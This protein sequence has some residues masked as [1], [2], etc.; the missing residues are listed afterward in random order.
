[1]YLVP[2]TISWGPKTQT[3][4]LQG[5]FH[6]QT[7]TEP[8]ESLN[9]FKKKVV[10]ILQKLRKNQRSRIKRKVD[11]LLREICHGTVGPEYNDY[12]RMIPGSH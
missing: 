11:M 12:S 2:T 6:V 8:E 5:T 7:T 1:M 9:A 4:E 3:H 10:A